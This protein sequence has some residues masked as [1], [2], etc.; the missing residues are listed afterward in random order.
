VVPGAGESGVVA[1][2]EDVGGAEDADDVGDWLA[3]P[4]AGVVVWD[5]GWLGAHA[6]S[7]SVAAAAAVVRAI[8][9]EII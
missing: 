1:G 5:C 9:W 2:A 6:V 4:V 7:S 3:C 8:A